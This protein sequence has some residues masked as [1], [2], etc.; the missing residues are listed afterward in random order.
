MTV[1]QYHVSIVNAFLQISSWNQK[2][3]KIVFASLL[4]AQIS[5]LITFPLKIVLTGVISGRKNA[6]SIICT[7]TV[8]FFYILISCK[9]FIIFFQPNSVGMPFCFRICVCTFVLLE[10]LKHSK[11]ENGYTEKFWIYC[12]KHRITALNL[13]YLLYF[14][15]S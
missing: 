3:S 12:N 13:R 5:C 11:L 15:W 10:F 1:H 14:R 8:Q 4:R 2:I 6:H 7:Y 9:V